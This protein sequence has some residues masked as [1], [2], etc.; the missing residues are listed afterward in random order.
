ML[1]QMPKMLSRMAAY[2]GTKRKLEP[3]GGLAPRVTALR[4]V[5][6]MASQVAKYTG[7][8]IPSGSIFTNF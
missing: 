4:V 7:A 6:L 2:T 8:N 1:E 3:E 5:V